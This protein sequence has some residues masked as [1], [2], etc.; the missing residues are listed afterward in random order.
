MRNIYYSI[1]FFFFSINLFSQHI[2]S[3][4]TWER[5][6]GIQNYNEYMS[7]KNNHIEHYD[8]GYIFH[9]TNDYPNTPRKPIL[10]KIDINGYYLWERKMDS[11]NNKY[12]NGTK[13]YINGGVFIWGGS[14]DSG[15]GNPWVAKLNACMEVEWCR[16][17]RWTE[18]SIAID[19]E[20]DQNGDIVVLTAYFGY[21]PGERINLI[22]M[23]PNGEVLWK[24][25]YATIENY[26]YI[27][28]AYARDLFI[29]SNNHYYIAGEANWPTNN[30]PGQGGG[31][32][33]LFIK[34]NPNGNEEWVLPFGIYDQIYGSSI[35]I[36]QITENKFLSVG[37]EG[38]HPILHYFNA[39]GE[40]LY[41]HTNEFFQNNYWQTSL[42]NPKKINDSSFFSIFSFFYTQ[43]EIY[44]H[45]GYLVFDTALNVIDY[46]EDDR[47]DAPSNLI[48]T[49][50]NKIVTVATMNEVE[51]VPY[52][53]IYL[54]K[55]NPDFT[56]DTVYE[57]WSGNY[58]TLCP[59]GIVSGYLPYNCN[60]VVGIDEIPTP[61][62]HQKAQQKI[63]ITMS[64]NPANGE[65]LIELENQ[66]ELKDLEIVIF[67]TAVEK[68]LEKSLRPY[69]YELP[70]DIKNWPRGVYFVVVQSEGRFVGNA[71]LVVE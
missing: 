57:D 25:N 39:N 4:T 12:I 44:G 24:E 13:N 68:L 8:K 38:I 62:E 1:I 49:F 6:F 3:D 56:Y 31:L 35:S 2:Y 15:I 36:T 7:A 40:E 30:D 10:R 69:E 21:S 32:R 17:F 23:A 65:V 71:K 14:Y 59:E 29:S 28:N 33:A 45:S 41:W 63:N 53:D 5:W 19:L 42:H 66:G 9:G 18:H 60:I 54:N 27:W 61:E 46:K 22:K 70:V 11:T 52:Y 20:I 16:I 67:N 43:D 34:V 55:L 48:H 51:K 50:N 58:D 26:P 37:V 64:P 47:W